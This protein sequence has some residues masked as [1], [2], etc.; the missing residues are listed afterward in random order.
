MVFSG[1]RLIKLTRGDVSWLGAFVAGIALSALVNDGSYLKLAGHLE[2]VVVMLIAATLSQDQVLAIRL[3]Q[4]LIWAAIV[5]A[6][7]GLLGALLFF[8]GEETPLLNHYG[9]LLPGD[10]PRIRG[11]CFKVNML[12]TIVATGLILL[13][14]EEKTSLLAKL[15]WPL[16]L[17]LGTALLFT[18]SRTWLTL[19]AG[20]VTLRALDE[21]TGRRKMLAI[22]AVVIVAVL[23]VVSARFTIQLEPTHFW[24]ATIT[25]EPGTR[26]VIW[27]DALNTVAANPIFGAGPGSPATDLGWSAHLVWLNLWAV[28]GVVPL[29]AFAVGTYRALGRYQL[30]TVVAVALGVILLDGLARDVEDMRHVWILMGLLLGSH[31]RSR[32]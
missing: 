13:P 2:L 10:Y 17:L 20:L 9:D 25:D 5:G 16:A 31:A 28:L 7:A 14:G 24:R 26:W 21:Q 3:R 15:R 6:T 30:E 23:L 18:F 8:L 27:G 12:A 22:A 32:S 1:R 19:G 4:A 11:T 29:C